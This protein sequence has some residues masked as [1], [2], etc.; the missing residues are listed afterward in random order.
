M[1]KYLLLL[2]VLSLSSC[3]D[4]TLVEEAVLIGTDTNEAATL[5]SNINNKAKNI[6]LFIGDGM[7]PKSSR[8]SKTFCG[9]CKPSTLV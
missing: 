8:V 1:K 6:I 5:D 7:G 9:W 3:Q 4:G 2:G